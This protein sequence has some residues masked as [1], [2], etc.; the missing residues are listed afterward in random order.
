MNLDLDYVM[1]SIEIPDDIQVQEVYEKDLPNDWNNFPHPSSTQI[2]GDNFVLENK[3]CILKIPSVVTKGD[4]NLLINPLHP[5]FKR[6]II[7]KIENFPFDK[8]IFKG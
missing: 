4:F 7:S 2:F 1:I 8:R 5:D 6:I 3:F